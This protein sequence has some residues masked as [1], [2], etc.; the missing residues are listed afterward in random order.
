MLKTVSIIGMGFV[1]LTTSAVF[2]QKNLTV[3]GIDNDDKK[4]RQLKAG[5]TPFFEPSLDVLVEKSVSSGNFIPTTDLKRSVND[6]ELV[7]IC[8]G[9]PMKSDGSV[10]LEYIKAVSR[11][12]GGAIGESPN[13]HV[14]SVKSTVPPGTTE[15]IVIRTI[16]KTSGKVCGKDFDITVTPEFLREG[17]AVVDTQNPHLVVIGSNSSKAAKIVRD[18]FIH[19]YG[20]RIK[21]LETNIVSAELIK[22]AN[23]SFLATKI[24]FINTIANICNRIP[25]AD[26]DVIAK[27]IGSDP[28]IG[29]QFLVAGPGY[30]GS[31]FPKDVSGFI[32]Y[33][34]DL[35][36]DP[37]L[38]KATDTVNKK[39]VHVIMDLLKQNLGKVDGKAI[40]ILGTAF[41]KDT[42][43][44]RESVSIKLIY[45][46][47][48][49]KAR[50]C[51]HDP[52]ALGNTKMLLGN[53]VRYSS[54]LREAVRGADCIILM[55]D[56]DEYRSIDE[57]MVSALAKC[58]LI[59][60]SRRIL[61]IKRPE[62]IRYI[63]LGKTG[64]K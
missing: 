30:G 40:T 16:E 33:C 12:I 2:A 4:I 59:I 44:I 22:Y 15:N 53:K 20:K 42:D 19:V 58:C 35:G 18:F 60:D 37:V 13:Y 36:Y 17:S 24:S 41:K 52:M 34:N 61:N 3:Y 11:Q 27:A 9:T 14:I 21:I 63:A 51:V 49:H 28:R 6:S 25:G 38:L 46:L 10:N 31:C 57:N 47:E 26:I 23:N 56:W 54:S 1:G 7:F 48:K 62:K 8:V 64:F 45:E 5:K 43:D 39:Q 55:T 32:Q 29:S 50:I